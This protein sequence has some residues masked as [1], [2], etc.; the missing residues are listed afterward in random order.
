MSKF[1]SVGGYA[2]FIWLSFLISFA[3]LA[4]IAIV[5]MRTYQEQK[6]RLAALEADE[7]EVDERTAA[8]EQ[9]G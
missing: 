8:P 3:V 6:A 1:F 4:G 9:V 5:S 2:V 7:R